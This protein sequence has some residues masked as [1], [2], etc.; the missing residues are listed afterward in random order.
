MVNAKIV[1]LGGG[2]NSASEETSSWGKIVLM[3]AEGRGGGGGRNKR[4]VCPKKRT[5]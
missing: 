1:D 4:G 3:E 5:E 2:R